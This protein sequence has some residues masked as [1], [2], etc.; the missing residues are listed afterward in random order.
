[1][2]KKT[3]K[4]NSSDMSVIQT[5]FKDR[6]I[7][8]KKATDMEEGEARFVA[9]MEEVQ[10]KE[11]KKAVFAP[12][13]LSS[14]ILSTVFELQREFPV[15]NDDEEE[16]EDDDDDEEEDMPLA[17]LGGKRKAPTVSRSNDKRQKQNSAS[18]KRVSFQYLLRCFQHISKVWGHVYREPSHEDYAW[19]VILF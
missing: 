17:F 5:A 19:Y 1:M 4:S 8:L 16:D 11:C 13:A 6:I 2:Q 18:E 14:I 12:A 15:T 7:K 3:S 9:H 10:V